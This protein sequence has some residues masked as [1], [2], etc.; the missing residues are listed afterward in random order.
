MPSLSKPSPVFESTLPKVVAVAIAAG[1]QLA[2]VE[3]DPDGRLRFTLENVPVDFE[4][5][6]ARDEVMVSGLK[7]INAMES[8]LTLINSHQRRGGRR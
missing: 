6:L 1:G 5:L 3:P 8:I 2:R 7:V 4:L